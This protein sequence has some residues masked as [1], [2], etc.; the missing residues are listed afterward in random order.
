MIIWRK[1]S[2]KFILIKID[3]K[4]Y[5]RKEKTYELLQN[6]RYT[7]FCFRNIHY[8][9]VFLN[10][11]LLY[12]LI[13]Y[14]GYSHSAFTE[15]KIAQY[16]YIHSIIHGMKKKK[17]IPLKIQHFLCPTYTLHIKLQPNY[18]IFLHKNAQQQFYQSF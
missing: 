13:S 2:F 1:N 12:Y 3:V 9:Q 16:I 7:F 8:Y 10:F 11:L 5:I 4:L 14:K 17:K 18:Y 6:N 15:F